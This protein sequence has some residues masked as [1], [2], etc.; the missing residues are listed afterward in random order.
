[1]IPNNFEYVRAQSVQE[2]L[3]F[4]SQYGDDSKLLAGGHSLIPAMKL[5]LNAPSKLI[6]ITRIRELN[7]IRKSDAT[8]QIGALATH[9]TVESSD[10]IKNNCTVLAE[11]AG[12]IGDPQVRNRGTIGG[13]LAHADPA[14]DYPALLLA[15]DADIEIAAQSGNRTVGADKFFTGFFETEL[16]SDE[17]ITQVRFPVLSKGTGAA[18]EKFPH[19]ASRFAVVGVAA[20][21]TVDSNGI[22]TTARVGVTGAA[23]S[24]FRAVDV[25][26][27]L[28]GKPLDEKAITNTTAKVADPANLLSDLIASAEYRAHLC[29][30]LAKRALMT[31][32][33]RAK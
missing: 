2:A 30:V 8:I 20:M 5:R 10:V 19:P 22:C 3:A 14:A 13:S 9:R 29:S 23:E 16:K 21:L 1:M 27:A 28:I 15:L 31:A 18:Y 17:I 32:M 25:E 26:N 6:D 12:K 11:T 4:L 33:E 7:D 24:A